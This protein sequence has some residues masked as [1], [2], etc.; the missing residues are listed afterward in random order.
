MCKLT[1]DE[2]ETV[3]T[4]LLGKALH[5]DHL[6]AYYFTDRYLNGMLYGSNCSAFRDL[7]IPAEERKKVRL[8]QEALDL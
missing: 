7:I 3:I 1:Y 5:S 6:I 4:P 2:F 8:I